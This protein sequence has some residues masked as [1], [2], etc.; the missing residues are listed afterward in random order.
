MLKPVIYPNGV[1]IKLSRA[2]MIWLP[3]AALVE[4]SPAEVRQ[5]LAANVKD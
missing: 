4:G 2:N 1:P 3:D 5:L